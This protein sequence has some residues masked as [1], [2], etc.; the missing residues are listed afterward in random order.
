MIPI[1]SEVRLQLFDLAIET[2]KAIEKGGSEIQE[3][4]ILVVSSKYAAVSEGQLVDLS[5]IIPSEKAMSLSKK[6][7]LE[8]SLA[9]LV[10]DDSEEIMGGINGFV[11]SVVRGTLAPNAGIDKSNVPKGWA[12]RYPRDPFKTA[13]QLREKLLMKANESG[14]SPKIR[15]LGVILS[16]SRVTP[17]RLGT[18]GVAISYSGIRPTIDM[19][20]TPDLLGNEL[21]V[22]LRAT[23][24]QLATAAQLLMGESNEG[25]PIVLIRGYEEAFA[26]P[27][28]GFEA[29]T[30]IPPDRCLIL[31]S[32]R[33]SN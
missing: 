8:P 31:S 30:T 5:K 4:D 15:R 27:R 3:G 33:N 9:Q 19:R 2:W 17:T 23:A 13:E 21:V 6:Y 22:T 12:V 18:T 32:L 7:N 20:G 29:K 14:V 25:R 26:E 16:D 10:L 28:N 24:D 11:L 1:S